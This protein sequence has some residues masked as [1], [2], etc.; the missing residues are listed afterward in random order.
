MCVIWSMVSKI[1]GK[2]LLITVATHIIPDILVSDALVLSLPK[3]SGVE[4]TVHVVFG[5]LK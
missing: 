4:N 5:M 1:T 3:V 2:T